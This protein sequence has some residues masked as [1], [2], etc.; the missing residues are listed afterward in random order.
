MPSQS[1]TDKPTQAPPPD[2]TAKGTQRP[3]PN[4]KARRSRRRRPPRSAKAN[5]ST[6]S[7]G[8]AQPTKPQQAPSAQPAKPRATDTDLKALLPRCMLQDRVRLA[9]QLRQAKQR[10]GLKDQDRQRLEEQARKSVQLLDRRRLGKPKITYPDELPIA[11]CKDEIRQAIEQHPVIIIAGETGSGKTTQLPKICL[12]A[13]RGIEAKIACT[14]P[15]RVAALSVSRRIAS[16]LDAVWGREVGCKI[17]FQDQT[18][19]ETYIK[20]MT[21]GMLLA[22]IQQDRRLLEYDTIIV[23]EAHERSLNIDFLLG[24]LKVLRQQ[25][26]DLK[27]IITSAT[28]DTEAFS[29]AF[30][31]APIIEVSGR[32]FPV[33][34]HYWPLEEMMGNRGDY[35]FVDASIEAVEQVL[36]ESD[37]GDILVFMPSERDIRETRERLEGRRFRNAEVVPLFGRLTAAEQ[38]RVFAP[39]GPRRIVVATNIA[40]TSLTI[41]RVRY[42]ID[43]GLARISRYNPRTQTQRLPIEPISQSSANQRKGRCGRVEGGICIRLYSEEEFQAK[44]EYTQPEI[45]RA[46]LADVILRMLALRLGAVETFPFIDPPKLQAIRGGYQLLEELG[47]LD[48]DKHLTR[49]GRSMARLPIAPTVSRMLLQAQEEGALSEVLVIAAAIS[50]QDPRERPL[51]QQEEADQMHKPFQHPDSDFLAFLNIWNAYHDQWD[52]LRTQSQMR[53]FCRQHF[54]SFMRMREWRDIYAQLSS[55]LRDI[56]GFRLNKQPAEYE[57]IHR[58]LLSGL[59]SNIALKKEHNFYQAARSR[60][61][62]IFPGSGLFERKVKRPSANSK[63]GAQAEDNSK[64]PAWMMAAEMVETS[65]LFA[66]TVARIQSSWL[67]DLGEHLCRSSYNEPFW[68]AR[69]GRVLVRERLSLYGLEVLVRNAPYSRVDPKAATEIFIREALVGD[70]IRASHPFLEHNRKL[71]DKIETWQTRQRS[72]DGFDVDQ[73]LFEFYQRHLDEVSSVH[74]LNRLIKDKRGENPRFL[75]ADEDELLD[76]R[77]TQLDRQAFP[78][79]LKLDGQVLPLEYA[80]KPGQE[81]DGITVKMPYKLIHAIDPEVLDWLVPGLLEEKVICLLRSLPKT[82][83]K[84]LVPIPQTARHIAAHMR[85]MQSS[86]LAS[87]AAFLQSEYRLTVKRGDWKI[88]ALPDH[89]RMRIAV[90]GDE[91]K[92]LVAG[93]ELSELVGRL[94]KHDTPVE[95]DAWKKEAGRWERNGVERW[96]MGDLPEMVQVADVSGVPLYG[97]PGL[98]HS[99][100]GVDVRLFKSRDEAEV[101]SRVG[102]LQLYGLT[103]GAELAW[104]QREL[105]ELSHLKD[106]YRSLGTVQEFKAD[107][108]AHLEQYLFHREPILPLHEAA[109]TKG[110]EQARTRLKGLGARFVEQIENLLQLRRQITLCKRPYP[111]LSDDVERLVPKGFLL[112]TP[113]MRLPHLSRYLRAVLLRAERV[114]LDPR[115]DAQRAAQIEPYHDK[116]TALLKEELPPGSPRRLAVEEFRWMVEEFRVSVFAQ[117]LGTDHPIS[118]KRLDKKLEALEHLA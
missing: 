106:L 105:Q 24:Y 82:L 109:F 69:S 45:Q 22:E 116:V 40:E 31:G 93:R 30:D 108:F 115:K 10:G 16:E 15:R 76:G 55:T 92:T 66:R 42:V 75:F 51:E 43:P 118:A 38:Q 4:E 19:P 110:L 11:A 18:A 36:A 94:E 50:I 88:D 58:S 47:A 41:P 81:E 104:L 112:H 65:R 96:D 48:A 83:R 46:N 27:I 72:Y 100:E 77:D 70:E 89:L 26:P 103:L 73:A 33:D 113:H 57:A 68:N 97:F 6:K 90:Q 102:L 54:L 84:T 117:E 17:R 56:G 20:M 35:T 23:D 1:T 39:K 67:P 99:A 60:E 107:A 111:T 52:Q 91:E 8:A 49:L 34:V 95:L 78:D 114:Q 29:Q 14:Q 7:S 63:G 21:D 53:K 2:K 13:G 74:D 86:F 98:Q 5:A 61:V 64:T 32:V 80:Y 9:R 28:I 71:R 12:E 59:L 3:Q 37:R 85:P 44:P 79:Q 25:R 101:A 87:L 62:M